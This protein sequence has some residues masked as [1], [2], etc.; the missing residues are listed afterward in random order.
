MIKL[1][2]V[3]KLYNTNGSVAI[4]IQDIN[5]ELFQNEI[6]VIVG[7]SGAGKTT[8]MN[9]IT[10]IDTY[11]EGDMIINDQSTADFSKED[12]DN[13]RNDNVGFIFQN[14]NLIESYTVLDNVMAPLLA[15]G[16]D[17]KEAKIKAKK[18][19]EDVG[20]KHRIHTRSNKLS[21]GEKQRCVIARALVVESKILACD[22]PTGNLDSKTGKEIISL[23]H[24]FS[25]NKLVL[26]VTHDFE[27]FKDVA[28]RKL[29]MK[30][31]K[32]IENKVLKQMDASEKKPVEIKKEKV[33]FSTYL[34]LALK[35]YFST[36]KRTIFSSAILLIQFFVVL[37]LVL[38]VA[39]FNPSYELV[40]IH[41]SN[42]TLKDEK[43]IVSY[44]TGSQNADDFISEKGISF[45][46]STDFFTC[47]YSL[48][49]SE[50]GFDY[51]GES[52]EFYLE[53]NYVYKKAY[54]IRP[55]F[56]NMDAQLID[57]VSHLEEDE[58]IIIY[59]NVDC[60][61]N[62]Y[63]T[64]VNRDIRVQISGEINDIFYE[65]YELVNRLTPTLKVVGIM[66]D[67]TLT[68]NFIMAKEQTL[69]NLMSEYRTR[70]DEVKTVFDGYLSESN[71]LTTNMSKGGLY[72]NFAIQ[73]NSYYYAYLCEKRVIK[74]FEIKENTIYIDSSINKDE[75]YI[76]FN[77]VLFDISKYK[78][79][80]THALTMG[81]TYMY[82]LPEEMAYSFFDNIYSVRSFY[83]SEDI[84]REQVNIL[85]EK[86]LYSELTA[87]EKEERLVTDFNFYAG[88]FSILFLIIIL[89]LSVIIGRVILS[90][91]YGGKKNDYVIMKV[92][93]YDEKK[94]SIINAIEIIFN[95]IITFA[96]DV[97][98]LFIVIN[99]TNMETISSPE[100]NPLFY[101]I[102][103]AVVMLI[104]ITFIKKFED[105]VFDKSIAAT[106]KAGDYLD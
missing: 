42:Y 86:G 50:Y 40:T 20:L 2:K 56:E 62:N 81:K 41:Q 6:V 39:N 10:G 23:I 54:H 36:P 98:V 106:L 47:K 93:G 85:N 73:A 22:E 96:I 102:S 49:P 15:R 52:Y 92:I 21:G 67:P 48:I 100:K 79:D 9:V 87:N 65:Q 83:E 63:N 45:D 32:I 90:L 94:I 55:Y 30:D 31:G 19:I 4:G 88:L 5:L 8:L 7:D 70:L 37:F 69:L 71:E 35:N 16:V 28:T 80:N 12:F 33:K 103:F 89:F 24:K 66:Y 91:I 99:V 18:I 74:E 3:T 97:V 95:A 64:T 76:G 60:K 26:I 46:D 11:E 51:V 101:I 44:P 57:G 78:I 61:V 82:I 53:N 58:I 29:V 13:Y 38:T 59:N 77:N 14:Y 43:T 25:D 75:F 1:E 104:T 84:T 34:R 17:Y 27:S 72:R 68:H 105:K